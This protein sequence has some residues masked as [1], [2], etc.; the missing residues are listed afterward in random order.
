MLAYS[1]YFTQGYDENGQLIYYP[2]DLVGAY[3]PAGDYP[4]YSNLLDAF[5]DKIKRHVDNDRQAVIGVFGPTGSGKSTLAI[6]QIKTLNKNW[7][8]APNLLYGPND[9]KVKLK[10][11]QYD[12]INLFDEGSVTFNSLE[13]TTTDAR[14]LT[15]IFDTMRSRHM[16]SFIVMPR[17]SDLNKR[18]EPHIDFKMETSNR[19]PLPGFMS[20]GFFKLSYPIRYDKKTYWQHM[21]TGIYDPM[22]KR[23]YNEYTALKRKKQ[24]A[25]LTDFIEG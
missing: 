19:A 16:I 2:M 15:V 8:L 18:I 20:R 24:D 12:P 3:G 22:S 5:A 11:G 6:D 25:I 10:A 21:G 14:K 7:K 13:T 17:Q 1:K 23:L 9:L 4:I